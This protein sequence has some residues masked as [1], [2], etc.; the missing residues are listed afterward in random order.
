MAIAIALV[1]SPNWSNSKTP[2]GPFQTTV[3]AFI[4]MSA[5]SCADFGPISK[6]M[7]SGASLSASLTTAGSLASKFLPVTTSTAIGTAAPL[8]AILF[9]RARAVGSK[10]S[11]HSE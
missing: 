3:P 8:A 2:K 9:I 1:P 7:S 6:I 4:I 5:S 10:S 11:S